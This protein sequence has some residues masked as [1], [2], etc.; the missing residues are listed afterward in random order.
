MQLES[1]SVNLIIPMLTYLACHR[2]EDK[3]YLFLSHAPVT[4]YF[5][6]LHV[7]VIGSQA[8]VSSP[9]GHATDHSRVG[10]ATVHSRHCHT[11]VQSLHVNSTVQPLHT[12]QSLHSHPTVHSLHSHPT[13][14]LRHHASTWHL[15][16]P[17][18][19]DHITAPMHILID[20]A[21]LVQATLHIADARQSRLLMR[22]HVLGRLLD[23]EQVRFYLL[24]HA[25]LVLLKAHFELLNVFVQLCSGCRESL[26]GFLVCVEFSLGILQCHIP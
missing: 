1:Q 7:C 2:C 10:H 16:T 8:A 21:F 13:T 5:L 6:V 15:H 26:L 4:V 24:G 22:H 12:V 23:F 17:E 25:D 20:T 3:L 9:H 19:I 14:K 11:T 18:R